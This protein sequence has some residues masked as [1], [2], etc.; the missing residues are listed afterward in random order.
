VDN[1]HFCK[2]SHAEGTA[3][4]MPF[5]L[6]EVKAAVLDCESFKSPGPDDIHMGF[7]KDFW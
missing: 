7:I 6:D 3:L 2:L 5:C 4:T 1:L